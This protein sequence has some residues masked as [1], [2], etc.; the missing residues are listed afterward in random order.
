MPTSTRYQVASS[1]QRREDGI[2]PAPSASTICSRPGVAPSAITPNPEPLVTDISRVLTPMV[3][4]G[5]M[6]TKMNFWLA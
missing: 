4:I 2:P 6:T 5:R 1:E 3:T